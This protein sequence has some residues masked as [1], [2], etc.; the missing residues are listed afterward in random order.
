MSLDWTGE[1]FIPG[2]RGVIETEH[3]HRYLLARTIA[4]GL[5][6]LDVASGEGYGSHLLSGVARS[7][8]GVDLSEDAVLHARETYQAANLRYLQ[9]DCSNLPVETASIDLVVSFETIE[10]HDRHD[11]ML[12]E[13]R[14]VLRP[15]GVLLISS[16]NRPEYDK[17]LS[18]PNPYHVKELDFAEFSD[19][20]KAHFSNAAFYAQR[21]LSGSAVVP[22]RHAETGFV[23]FSG[24][25]AADRHGELDRPIYFVAVASDGELPALGASLYESHGESLANAAAEFLE[26]RVYLSE[27]V[28]GAALPY[29]EARGAAQVYHLDGAHK[30]LQFV[31]PVDLQPLA[32]LRLDIANAP[33]AIALHAL[34]LHGADGAE[35]WRWDGGCDAFASPGGVM[36]WP[37]AEGVLLLCLNNDPQFELAIPPQ[38]LALVR[39]AASLRIELTP[40]PLLDRLPGV[41]AEMQAQPKAGLP[42]LAGAHVPVGFSRHLE[43]LAGLL[44]MQIDRKNA[45]IAAQHAEIESMR[46]RQQMLYEQ[47]VRAEAQLELLKEFALPEANAR[48]ERL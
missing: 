7:V 26:A 47:V 1:R 5:D 43:E 21:V 46:V 34:A 15:G 23:N 24:A 33:A 13:V 16:P 22:Y 36:C 6:V 20:L 37:A 40:M 28:N 30:T 41:L 31:F 19:L 12:H 27:R 11:A 9:G 32:R 44:K 8:L 45:T 42:A 2:M 10:H 39:G 3:L 18:E 25:E 14:R 35:I 17:T 4:A 48:L 38:V 29:G